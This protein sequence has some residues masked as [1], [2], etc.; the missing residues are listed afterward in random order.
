[1]DYN[2][3]QPDKRRGGKGSSTVV[4]IIFVITLTILGIVIGTFFAISK[5]IRSSLKENTSDYN[6]SVTAEITENLE[7]HE[8]NVTIYTPVYEY[9]YRGRSYRVVGRVS[10]RDK[11]YE[12]GQKVDIMIKD[13]LPG[14]IYDPGLNRETI[15]KNFGKEAT[16]E[17]LPFIIVPLLFML[18]CASVIIIAA[19]HNNTKKRVSAMQS[20]VLKPEHDEYFDP[21]DDYRG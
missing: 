1:M 21:N 10:M 11:K 4:I 18:I 14:K 20:M 16:M 9:E 6:V 8:G 3:Q 12:V 5:T 17:I 19:A 7:R 2:F 15:F 13:Q